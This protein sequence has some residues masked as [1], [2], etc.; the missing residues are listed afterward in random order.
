MS[1]TSLDGIDA[2]LVETDGEDVAVPGPALTL[3]YA[4]ELRGT[5]AR[6]AGRGE[7]RGGRRARA[8]CHPRCR[9]PLDR[10]PCRSG[11]G[12]AEKGGR[13]ARATFR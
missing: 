12:A 2:A 13:G 6:G 11:E 5:S 7:G 1:G 3:P 8:V 10:S 9:A 4:P